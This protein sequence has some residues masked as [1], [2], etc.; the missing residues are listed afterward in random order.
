M[1]LKFNWMLELKEG[2][3][4]IERIKTKKNHLCLVLLLEVPTLLAKRR[5]IEKYD[6]EPCILL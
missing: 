5:C 2:G 3:Q 1:V 4:G 6:I